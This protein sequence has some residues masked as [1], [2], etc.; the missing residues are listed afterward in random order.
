MRVPDPPQEEHFP[1]PLP[2]QNVHLKPFDLPEPLQWKHGNELVPLPL[3]AEQT[4]SAANNAVVTDNTNAT[5]KIR[6]VILKLL[7]K[8]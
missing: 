3:Q 1:K 5:A 6:L 2:L 8:N 7:T 4:L